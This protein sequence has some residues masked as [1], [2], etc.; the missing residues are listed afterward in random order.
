MS[1]KKTLWLSAAAALGCAGTLTALPAAAY[2][3]VDVRIGVPA[4][5]V[6]VAPPPAPRYEVRPAPRRGYV[7]VPGHWEGRRNGPVWVKGVFLRERHGYYYSQPQWVRQ[8]DRWAYRGGGWSR[9]DRDHERLRHRN[10]RD[11]DGVPNA[12]D[13]A[14]GNPYRH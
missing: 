14:P 3:S 7:W 12:Y 9:R 6:Y 13:R 5:Q 4:P 10:D 11:H 1:N 2:A 8:G